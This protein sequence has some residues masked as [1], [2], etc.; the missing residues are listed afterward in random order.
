[1]PKPAAD[2]YASMCQRIEQERDVR[3][4][5]GVP[6]QHII[7]VIRNNK[8]AHQED[9]DGMGSWYTT[10]AEAKE[11][12]ACVLTCSFLHDEDLYDI[13]A[14]DDRDCDHIKALLHDSDPVHIFEPLL[15]RQLEH[16]EV[17]QD[18][19]LSEQS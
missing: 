7:W 15:M 5:E 11:T 6:A 2:Q 19:S 1:M 3:L 18:G 14:V 12:C 10:E 8:R 17:K 9:Y 13:R 16:L 4:S